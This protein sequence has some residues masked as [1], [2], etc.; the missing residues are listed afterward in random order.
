MQ[1]IHDFIIEQKKAFNDTFK[2]ESGLE[3]YG[4]K[5]FLADKLSNRIA[6]VIQI[7][8]KSKSVIKA[9][10]EVMIDPTIYYEQNYEKGGRVGNQFLQDREKGLYKIS[11]EMIVMYRENPESEW[12]GFGPNLLVE[13]M[14]EQVGEKPKSSLVITE[15][16]PKEYIPGIAKVKYPN[17]EI[18]ESGANAGDVISIREGFGVPFYI[19]G[20]EFFWIRNRDVYAVI[21][22]N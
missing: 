11:P 20:K 8:L 15:L 1:A 22:E 13:F 5:R 4:D 14:K 9:G 18:I 10:Y 17:S 3:L 19:D 2:T 7:P 12:K 16:K 21:N 6:T